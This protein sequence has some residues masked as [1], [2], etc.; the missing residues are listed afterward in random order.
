MLSDPG[1]D[2]GSLK[3]TSDG[4]YVALDPAVVSMKSA[5]EA[6]VSSILDHSGETP[7][8]V[9]VTSPL[10]IRICGSV[11]GGTGAGAIAIAQAAASRPELFVHVIVPVAPAVVFTMRA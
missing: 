5:S 1:V 7:Q 11:G 2:A 6:V 3:L 10:G 8:P 9:V 4:P